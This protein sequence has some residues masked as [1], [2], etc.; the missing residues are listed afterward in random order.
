MTGN[1]LQLQHTSLRGEYVLFDNKK[2]VVSVRK[3]IKIFIC[4]FLVFFLDLLS[5]EIVTTTIW[6]SYWIETC[7]LKRTII[8]LERSY[9]A[10]KKTNKFSC[11]HTVNQWQWFNYRKVLRKF[12][13][14][15]RDSEMKL[16]VNFIEEKS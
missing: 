11:F 13:P 8:G 2:I 4:H 7:D 9:V 5:V 3:R 15:L 6:S 16:N 12:L 10:V 1:V 14:N